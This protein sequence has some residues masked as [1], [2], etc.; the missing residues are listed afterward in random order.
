MT[1]GMDEKAPSLPSNFSETVW[2][3]RLECS[4]RNFLLRSACKLGCF[5]TVIEEKKKVKRN[6]EE[7]LDSDPE[8]E[9]EELSYEERFSEKHYAALPSIIFSNSENPRHKLHVNCLVR[10]PLSEYQRE[11]LDFQE[12]VLISID[13]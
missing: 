1:E 9:D 5:Y 2:V 7:W 8:D 11:Q 13:K 6:A 3:D 10:P 12:E 4:V